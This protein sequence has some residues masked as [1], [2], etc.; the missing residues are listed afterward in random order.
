[1]SATSP[2]AVP[3]LGY[4]TVLDAGELGLLGGYLL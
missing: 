1:M 4:L 2:K 3:T